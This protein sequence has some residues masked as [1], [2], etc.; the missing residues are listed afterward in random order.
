MDLASLLNQIQLH[1]KRAH[2]FHIHSTLCLKRNIKRELFPH[3]QSAQQGKNLL[4][5]IETYLLSSLQEIIKLEFNKLL[6]EEKKMFFSGI[7]YDSSLFED[8]PCQEVFFLKEKNLFIFI[9]IDNHLTFYV[10][11]ND[12]LEGKE[13]L[14]FAENLLGKKFDY[15]FC[16]NF[17]FITYEDKNL[18]NGLEIKSYYHLP[19]ISQA[20][21]TSINQGIIVSET[22][23]LT[24]LKN[25]YNLGMSVDEL[26]DLQILEEKKICAEQEHL[27]KN[28]ELLFQENFKSD[29]AKAFGTLLYGYQL[30]KEELLTSLSLI[31][32]GINLSLF[33]GISD[34]E[35]SKLLFQS[36]RIVNQE[37]A[38]KNAKELI[39][40][41]SLKF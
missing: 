18:G 15:A 39:L 20:K 23:P 37:E 30:K 35:I 5:E 17:G 9:N 32:L 22:L 24:V 7:F 26:F 6:P 27:R 13:T 8:R 38:A 21:T 34:D 10:M 33:A 41:G 3:K 2:C 29:L 12:L 1:G 16:P 25:G 31:K 19:L 40:K 36:M 4:N 28:L 14:Y 11:E